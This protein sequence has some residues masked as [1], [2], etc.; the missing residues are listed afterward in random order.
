MIK[1]IPA[2]ATMI[3]VAIASLHIT[4]EAEARRGVKLYYSRTYEVDWPVR[5]YEGHVAP[6]HYCSY[7]R[8]PKRF[9]AQ[10]NLAEGCPDRV[11]KRL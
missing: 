3:G 7:K 11:H 6:G 5:G 4:G 2:T 8:Y 1:Y 10:S 9:F